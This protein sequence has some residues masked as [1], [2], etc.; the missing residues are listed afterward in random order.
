MKGNSALLNITKI[1]KV[2]L[3]IVL[4]LI[5]LYYHF[6]LTGCTAEILSGC[7]EDYRLYTPPG[8]CTSCMTDSQIIFSNLSLILGPLI[9]SYILSCL[10]IFSYKKIGKRR[11]KIK[12]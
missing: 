9:F 7:Q 6:A 3:T 8:G 1:W 11:W 4:T 5:I 10:I 12:K 2:I